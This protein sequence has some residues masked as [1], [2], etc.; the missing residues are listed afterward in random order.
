MVRKIVITLVALCVAMGAA[1]G[2]NRRDAARYDTMNGEGVWAVGV[3]IVPLANLV[4]PAG[5]AYGGLQST[6]GTM[7]FGFEGSY[8]VRD[9]WRAAVELLYT[10]DSYSSTFSS[11][12]GVAYSVQ[13]SFTMGL[14]AYR[15]IGRW[16][17]GA[18]VSFGRS[19]LKYRAAT[20]EDQPNIEKYGDESFTQRKGSVGLVVS[21]GY[22]VS[23]FM[24]VGAFW[25]PSIAG[26][27]YAHSLGLSAT[28]YL[29]FVDAV[30][31]K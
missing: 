16:Y 29:P 8:F 30:V 10:D 21:G 4:H 11:F 27:G 24:K 25:R 6:T 3:N 14:M 26:G 31:C 15:H 9:G 20:L 23:P 1:L 28:I 12:S 13:S 7:G 2:Q 5:K 17:A 18:G 19:S 22:Q